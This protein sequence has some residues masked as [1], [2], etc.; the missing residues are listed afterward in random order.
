M[1]RLLW[2]LVA[3]DG[4]DGGNWKGWMERLRDLTKVWEERSLCFFSATKGLTPFASLFSK[5]DSAISI[6]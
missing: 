4:M 1:L 6:L 3:L 5:G 2:L